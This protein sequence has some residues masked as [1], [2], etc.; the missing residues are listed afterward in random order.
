MPMHEAASPPHLKPTERRGVGTALLLFAIALWGSSFAAMKLILPGAPE[1]A[2]N[3]GRFAVAAAALAPFARLGR[4]LW[5]RGAEL[6]LW[7]FIGYATQLIGLRRTSMDRSAFITSMAVVIVPVLGAIAGQKVRKIVCLA[8]ALGVAGCA[9]MCHDGGK[10][11]AGDYWTLA[12]A[13]FYAIYMVRME[14]LAPQFPSL[15]LASAQIT[16]VMVLSALWFIPHLSE[17][18]ALPWPGLLYLGLVCTAA[19][20]W[21]QAI[22]QKT[23]PAPQ[24]ALLFTL[25]PVFAAAFGFAL[26]HETLGP[27]GLIGAG[28]I[29]VAAMAACVR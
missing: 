21:L 28:L 3:L 13:F 29:V 18:R 9:L 8:A 25:E 24:T 20:T 4:R 23:V 14:I 27:R 22:A 12:T 1:A 2:I 5:T 7:L 19:T 6:G 15:P 26:L 16:T 10:V 11:N 17:A